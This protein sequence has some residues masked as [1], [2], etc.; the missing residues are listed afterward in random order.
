MPTLTTSIIIFAVCLVLLFFFIAKY[1]KAGAQDEEDNFNLLEEVS[2]AAGEAAPY[3]KRLLAKNTGVGAREI[4]DLKE[5]V[6]ELSYHLEEL[7][8][9]EEKRNGELS[10]SITKLEQRIITFENEYVNKLQP[11]LSGLISELE[12]IQQ[13]KK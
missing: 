10:K 8:L 4:F 6:K 12:N 2:A 7:K 3:A 13:A 5:K 1:R 9:L 11:A